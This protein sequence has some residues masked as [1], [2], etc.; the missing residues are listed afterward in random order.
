MAEW[1]EEMQPDALELEQKPSSLWASVSS[2][3]K[4]GLYVGINI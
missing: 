4:G 1:W 2:P 3:I